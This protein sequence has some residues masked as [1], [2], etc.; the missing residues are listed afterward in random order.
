MIDYKNV[1]AK[2]YTISLNF[3]LQWAGAVGAFIGMVLLSES[4]LFSGFAITLLGCIA[5]LLFAWRNKI[6]AYV[7]LDIFLGASA[8]NGMIGL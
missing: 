2:R 7:A 4:L 8:I 3:I 6:W 1:T 5:G